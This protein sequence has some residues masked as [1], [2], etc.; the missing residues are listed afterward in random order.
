MNQE[1]RKVLFKIK[2]Y[3]LISTVAIFGAIVLFSNVSAQTHLVIDEVIQKVV[4]V[5]YNPAEVARVIR[6]EIGTHAQHAV[7]IA[8]ATSK[9]VPSLAIV[10]TAAAVH[11][12]PHRAA[13]IWQAISQVA[14]EQARHV[15]SSANLA[16]SLAMNQN[17][18]S[19]IIQSEL[20]ALPEFA[21]TIVAAAVTVCDVLAGCV[22]TP[23]S[24]IVQGAVAANRS[25]A[26]SIVGAAVSLVP[27]RSG[28]I[29][30][31]ADSA[32]KDGQVTVSEPMSGDTPPTWDVSPR[33]PSTEPPVKLPGSTFR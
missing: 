6:T 26:E 2:S 29:I 27:A 25:S 28:E 19:A 23:V 5:Q 22:Q 8:Q 30:A 9:V 14:S 21:S 17:R 20:S 33:G 1:N 32:L 7:A 3:K 12:A 18:S 16:A 4:A 24:S 11:S 31:V 13:E 15:Q 10:I